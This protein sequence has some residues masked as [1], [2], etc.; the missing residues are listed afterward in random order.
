M[1]TCAIVKAF[2]RQLLEIFNMTRR[3]VRPEFED[4]F[5]FGGFK[6]GDFFGS[7]HN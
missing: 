2:I 4:H 7:V 1:E 5:A 3:N 6:N